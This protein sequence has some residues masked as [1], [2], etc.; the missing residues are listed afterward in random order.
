MAK[1]KEVDSTPDVFE[2]GEALA[3]DSADGW[4]TFKEVGDR[5]GGVIKD[6]F[7]TQAKDG[8][9]AQRVFTLKIKDG[10][11]WNVGLKRT[12]YTMTR[13]NALQ[14]GD[15][16]GI[17]FEKEIPPKKKGFHPAKSLVFITKKNGDRLIGE[18]AKDLSPVTSVVE[19]THEEITEDEDFKKF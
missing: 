3:R 4:Y 11:L 17:T 8:F 6:M 7:E 2:T 18:Q 14:I 9:A 12:G 5:I 13:T 15:E 16:L 10:S 1:T 19:E